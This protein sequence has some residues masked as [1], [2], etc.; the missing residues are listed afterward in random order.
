MV[1]DQSI[2][3]GTG[4]CEALASGWFAQPVDAWSSLAYTVIGVLVVIAAI[5]SSKPNRTVALSFGVLMGATGVGSFLYHVP[6]GG[7]AGFAHD[8]TFLATL[9]FLAVM[10]PAS[11]YGV[12]RRTAWLTWGAGTAAMSAILLI[13]PDATNALTAIAVVALI[14]SDFLMHRVGGINGRWYAAA[15]LLFAASLAFNLAGRTGAPTCDPDSLLQFHSAWHALSAAGL[16]AYFVA[17]T[18]PRNQEPNP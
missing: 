11:P 18:V 8:I 13:A 12:A 5:R 6:Q 10:D 16:G 14:G 3:L 7:A 17:M 4:D 15:L 9:W 2:P 1:F